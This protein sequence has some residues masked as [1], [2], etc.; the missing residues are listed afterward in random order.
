MTTSP[1][2][3]IIA[4]AVDAAGSPVSGATLRYC[5]SN[6]AVCNVDTDG[7]IVATSPGTATVTI[8]NGSVSRTITV[9]V[10]L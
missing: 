6:M 2:A 5:T 7:T 4:Q 3:T 9:N 1:T 8:C 10:T